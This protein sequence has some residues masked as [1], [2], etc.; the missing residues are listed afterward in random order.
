MPEC[1]VEALRVVWSHEICLVRATGISSR[2]IPVEPFLCFIIQ[3]L[4]IINNLDLH[5]KQIEV[6]CDTRIL[7]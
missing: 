3:N 2:K 5:F 6:V 4:C 7:N 1:N